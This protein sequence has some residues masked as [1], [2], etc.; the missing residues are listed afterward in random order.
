LNDYRR[1]LEWCKG[2]PN[3]CLADISPAAAS[4]SRGALG[5]LVLT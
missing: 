3:P 2:V 5:F 1:Q 4:W